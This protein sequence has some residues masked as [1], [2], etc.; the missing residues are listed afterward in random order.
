VK[1][2]LIFLIICVSIIVYANSLR[3]EFVWDD[4]G[5]IVQN[6]NVKSRYFLPRIFSIHL[7]HGINQTSNFYRPIQILSYLLD[8]SVWKLNPFGYHLTNLL[9]HTI[10]AI[11]VYILIYLFVKDKIISLITSLIFTVHPIHTSVVSYIS[12]RADL[13][14]AF[15]VFLSLALFILYTSAIR[16]NI[17]F[18]IG[19]IVGFIL[20]LL[21]KEISIVFPLLLVGYGLSFYNKKNNF[22]VYIPYFLIGAVFIVL[23]LT[24]LNFSTTNIFVS[25]I[26]FSTRLI[27]AFKALV[28]Y[29][30]LLILPL[31]L[32]MERSMP[33]I[34]GIFDPCLFFSLLLVCGIIMVL[35]WSYKQSKEI[36]FGIAWFLINLIPVSNLIIPLNAPLAE[37]W[38]YLPSIG[39]FMICSVCIVNLMGTQ[40]APKRFFAVLLLLSLIIFY[41]FTTIRQN[42]YWY[43]PLTLYQYT[44]KFSPNSA[45]VHRNLG[46]YYARKGMNNEAIAEYKKSIKLDSMLSDTYYSLG[47][48]YEKENMYDEAIKTYRKAISLNPQNSSPHHNLGL[49]Y[50][51]KGLVENALKEFKEAIRI[52]PSYA[53]AH[54]KIGVIYYNQNRYNEAIEEYKKSIDIDPNYAPSYDSLGVIYAQKGLYD[55]ALQNCLTALKIDPNFADAHKNIGIIYA[56]MV[57]DYKKA[58]EHFERYLELKPDTKDRVLI[59]AE[60]SKLRILKENDKK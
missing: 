18:Y 33:P 42:L 4:E 51:K 57:K 29:I 45:R 35:K 9:L 58:I 14:A 49:I 40:N 2:L 46:L 43:N 31:T 8:Y 39:F 36:F 30:S 16:R 11:L 48:V 6:E 3:N 54:H 22:M 60:L 25:T 38:L 10:N 7:A 28:L 41:S 17:L 21:S 20:A 5:L 1:N 19:S 23:R 26:S 27:V 44:L 59:E 24:I 53:L 12:G 32:H 55:E 37:H 13:L 15:F 34:R 50:Y 47:N 56:S 52:N